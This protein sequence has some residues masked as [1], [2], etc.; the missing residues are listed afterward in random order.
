[1]I[2]VSGQTRS[3]TSMMMYCLDK[4]GVN[5]AFDDRERTPIIEKRFRNIYGFYEG[6]WNEDE[7]AIK[8]LS[9]NGLE[10]Y[11][12]P[13]V[14]FM[15][16]DVDKRI[17]SWRAVKEDEGK[18]LREGFLRP[19]KM[20]KRKQVL[21]EKLR[22]IPH[23]LVDYDTFVNEPDTY[24]VD[25]LNLLPELDFEKIKSGIDKKLYINRKT[26]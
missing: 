13:R 14:I 1:M 16:R 23:I 4:A 12:N 22:D 15:L 5:M 3:G 25:F 19:E 20:L 8:H 9:V 21:M 6:R 10:Q 11:P 26:N 2:I 24:K 7:G 17:A 18:A